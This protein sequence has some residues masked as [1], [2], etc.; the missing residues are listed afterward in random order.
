MKN[1]DSKLK[2]IKKSKNLDYQLSKINSRFTSSTTKQINSLQLLDIA[3]SLK[4]E[5]VTLEIYCNRLQQLVLVETKDSYSVQSQRY[6]KY[7]DDADY[8]FDGLQSAYIINYNNDINKY[9]K[10]LLSLYSEMSELKEES[11]SKSKYTKD[12]FKNGI[13]IDDARYI[14]PTA[15]PCNMVMTIKGDQLINLIYR[16]IKEKELMMHL[17]HD[18]IN[19][20]PGIE[21]IVNTF[22]LNLSSL[23]TND[24]QEELNQD[25]KMYIDNLSIGGIAALT[26][27]NSEPPS[28]LAKRD[29]LQKVANNVV[30][31]LNHTSVAEHIDIDI[32][33]SLSLCCYNQLVRHRHQNIERTQFSSLIYK[34]WLDNEDLEKLIIIPE[35]LNPYK[36]KITIIFNNLHDLISKIMRNVPLELEDKVASILAQ[37]LPMGVRLGL[38]INSNLTNELYIC[39]KR[40]CLLAHWEIREFTHKKINCLIDNYGGIPLI[41]KTYPA[42][43]KDGCKEGKGYCGHP[44]I[45]KEIF[46]NK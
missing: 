3:E 19:E 43:L 10:S 13:P 16:I 1:T 26:C 44:E 12:D 11:K 30:S 20:L 31:K 5:S 42:C 41:T 2:V 35:T 22:L 6:C 46:N 27:T 24:N 40:T 25:F 18:L 14:I 38:H 39:E 23:Y 9:M 36:E 28:E 34:W 15:F 17:L 45:V 21:I 33:T 32:Q 4:N 37:L 7:D 8:V 29:N